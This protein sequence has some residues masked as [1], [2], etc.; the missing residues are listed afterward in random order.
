MKACA[1]LADDA[2][3]G[4][5][6]RG[7]GGRRTGSL[8]LSNVRLAPGATSAPSRACLPADNSH[9]DESH[10][11]RCAPLH[12]TCSFPTSPPN[13]QIRGLL[14]TWDAL[15]HQ[16]LPI[17]LSGNQ[18]TTRR[19]V[20]EHSRNQEEQLP[21]FDFPCLVPVLPGGNAFLKCNKV[22]L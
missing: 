4:N 10:C 17:P 19:S 21:R 16:R 5:G 18:P 3:C 15:E 20:K 12:I 6:S 11:S 1:G 2:A 14:S 22:R 7:S 9:L 8:N 13:A